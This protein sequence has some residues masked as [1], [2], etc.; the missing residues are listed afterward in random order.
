M[1]TYIC[2]PMS[3][4]ACTHARVYLFTH[5]HDSY[6]Y[7]FVNTHVCRHIHIDNANILCKPICSMFAHVHIRIAHIQIC[8][9]MHRHVY[10][11]VTH[12]HMDARVPTRALLLS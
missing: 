6:T 9:P 11:S 2:K 12:M 8:T 3:T 1:Y 7:A 10:R 5:S 4:L